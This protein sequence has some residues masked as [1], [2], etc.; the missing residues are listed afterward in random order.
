[1]ADTFTVSESADIHD[2]DK[3]VTRAF[4]QSREETFTIRQLEHQIANIDTNIE[5]L[6]AE[7]AEVQAKIDSANTAIS[8]G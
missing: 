8:G 2:K 6:N 7:K 4:T 5:M 3:K 1:M